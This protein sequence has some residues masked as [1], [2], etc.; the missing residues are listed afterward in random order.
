MTTVGRGR[1]RLDA[2]IA[3]GGMGEVWRGTDTS[4][5]RTVAIKVL[6]PNVSDDERFRQRFAAEAQYAASLHDP[7]IATVFDYGDDV[8]ASTGQ[9]ST[10]LVME[11][12]DGVPMS[13]V[14]SGPMD[15]GRAAGLL[16]QVAQGLAV[17]HTAGIVHRDV[18]PA[19]FIVRTDGRVK[20]TDFGISRARGAASLT[21]TGTIM[22]TPHYLAPEIA[23]GRE[24]TPAS[25][26][27][28]LGVVLFEALSGR[29]PFDGDTP[30]AIALAHL[31]SEPHVLPPTVPAALR[32]IVESAMARD[33]QARP[34]SAAAVATALQKVAG[35]PGRA[36]G[37]PQEEP[38][39]TQVLPTEQR[40]PRPDDTEPTPAGRRLWLPVAAAA[41]VVALMVGVAY[42][43][44]LG[45]H[46]A[47]QLGANQLAAQQT[48]PAGSRASTP[49][50]PVSPPVVSVDPSDYV[51]EPADA[52]EKQ[53]KALGL[54][55]HK[56]DVD[57]GDKGLVAAV[58][59]T[60]AVPTGQQVTLSVYKGGHPSHDKHDPKHNPE[61][62]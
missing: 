62:D 6:H 1:Y 30:I 36:V 35:E 57:G 39:P 51:D 59:P 12:V 5:G 34:P 28:S 9:H 44:Q 54:E 50:K 17:A 14:M 45:D 55:V 21:D 22:G 10:Y 38:S 26:I 49:T 43:A 7:H 52:A 60:G 23:E 15:P 56:Q 53:L 40:Q 58:Q 61:E 8:D 29:K 3:A 31:R 4:L 42:A 16:A 47:T 33:P 48:K 11:L 2:R 25:D 46:P 37:S 18:K 32:T 27:Y 13:D 41:A 24:A 20:I 19:N